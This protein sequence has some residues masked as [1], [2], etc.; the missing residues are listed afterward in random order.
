ML[1]AAIAALRLLASRAVVLAAAKVPVKLG[2]EPP[3]V[4]EPFVPAVAL[5]H[6]KMLVPFVV[7]KLSWPTTDSVTVTVPFEELVVRPNESVLLQ[8]AICELRFPAT[9][10]AELPVG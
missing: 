10:V 6:E 7:V 9:A 8:D 1:Q 2:A 4:A 5:V 3:Q